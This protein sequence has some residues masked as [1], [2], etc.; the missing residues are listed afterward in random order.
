[1]IRWKLSI[2]ATTLSW[3]STTPFGVPVVPDVKI[4]SNVSS[5]AGRPHAPWRTSQSGGKSGSSGSGSAERASTVV[6]GKPVRRAS[7]GSGASRP[8]PRM[9]WR[10]PEAFTIPST[11][12]ADMRRSSG[13]MTSRAYIAP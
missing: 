9:R 1:M 10:A 12:S 11:A 3:V 6:V 13:T 4:S 8:V 7:R 2:D 5:A